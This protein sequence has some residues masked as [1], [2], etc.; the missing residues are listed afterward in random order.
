VDSTNKTVR[1]VSQAEEDQISRSIMAWAQTFPERPVGMIDYEYLPAS[2][3]AMA[4]SL[5]QGT[6][7]TKRYLLGGHQAEYQ[8]KLIYRIK[9]GTSPDKR[10]T[11]D[12]V[13]NRFGEWAR[14]NP[15]KLEDINIIRME[16]TTRAALFA[17]YE[18]DTEDHQILMRL[19]YEVI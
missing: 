16:P 11:A 5:I 17:R 8:Y 3:P 2:S 14:E 6:A 12:E 13:L 1:L 19:T 9:P 15:P 10:L 18:D 4:V 7:I